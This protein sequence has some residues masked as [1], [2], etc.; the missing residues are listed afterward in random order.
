MFKVFGI[1]NCRKN[2]IVTLMSLLLAGV[3]GAL[4]MISVYAL[5]TEPIRSNVKK[6]SAVF[7]LGQNYLQWASPIVSSRLDSFTDNWMINIATYQKGENIKE[8]IKDSMD[9]PWNSYAHIEGKIDPYNFIK[10]AYTYNVPMDGAK[11]DTYS[12]YWHGY[13]IWLKPMLTFFTMGDIRIFMM[14]FQFI[15]LIFVMLELYKKGGLKLL[16]PFFIAILIFNPIS[17]ALCLTYSTLYN[18][19][20][21][22]MLIN[23]KYEL[24]NSERY[25]LLFLW[26]GIITSFFDFLTYPLTAL[27]CNLI[28]FVLLS[29]YQLFPKMKKVIL[30]SALWTIGYAGMWMEKWLI[31]SLVT[32]NNLFIQAIRSGKF[33]AGGNIEGGHITPVDVILKNFTA[34]DNHV[35]YTIFVICVV[36]LL[37]CYLSGKYKIKL[38]K[39]MIFP[40][41]FVGIYPFVWFFVMKNH[42]YGHFWMVHKILMLTIIAMAYAIVYSI[43]EKTKKEYEIWKKSSIFGIDRVLFNKILGV[44]LV[45]LL[46]GGI[47]FNVKVPEYPKFVAVDNT[48]QAEQVYARVHLF[49]QGTEENS[50]EITDFPKGAQ[51]TYPNWY[52]RKDGNG[53]VVQYTGNEMNVRANIKGDGVL[54]ISLKG[55]QKYS[56]DNKTLLAIPV[57]YTA[58]EINGENVLP[59]SVMVTFENH[60]TYAMPVKDGEIID[61]VF[62]W[63]K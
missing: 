31:G 30:S 33:R 27:G 2:L 47:A 6:S 28:I 32:G 29:N 60:F 40:L 37:V 46:I 4:L 36:L 41:L 3:M 20:L 52:K 34:I 48:K 43:T 44:G 13:N 9:N 35:I 55:L 45:F 62:K 58:L 12:R 10:K 21:I 8:I 22:S 19:T 51:V 50:V 25:W 38:R 54:I 59:Q 1:E 53:G 39:D 56:E 11:R 63:K 42:S 24:W 16:T 15:L 61:F 23:L 18:I 7:D 17:C 14:M 49:N 57:T 5:P 26:I